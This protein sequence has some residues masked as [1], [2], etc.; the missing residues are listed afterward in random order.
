MTILQ[1]KKYFLLFLIFSFLLNFLPSSAENIKEP[2]L[3]S[4]VLNPLDLDFNGSIN[5]IVV[6]EM[7]GIVYVGGDFKSI[8]GFER[9]NLAAI[10]IDGTL[11]DWDPNV[12]GI[13]A[14]GI[15]ATGAKI[16]AL[17]IK[18]STIY[19]GGDFTKIGGIERNNLAAIGTNGTLKHWNPNTDGEVNALAIKG[20]TIYVGGGFWGVGGGG[21]TKIGET[22]RNNLAAIGTDGTL[23]SWNP[24]IVGSVYNIV[25][26]GSTIYIG[27]DF[28]I[29]GNFSEGNLAAIGTDGT[30]LDWNP[31]FGAS[32]WALATKGSTIYVGGNFTEVGG[33]ERNLLAAIGTE[34]TIKNWNP[35]INSDL[36]YGH[37]YDYPPPYINTIAISGSTI[38]VGGWFA[39]VGNEPRSNFASFSIPDGSQ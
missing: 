10:G 1:S 5:A 28:Y 35:N 3:K 22:G 29:V 12:T 9:N 4:P 13:T 30:F 8:G 15:N 19:V 26:K 17:A 16:N 32:V 31:G 14:T 11:L 38:Y 25:I 20:S 23:Q 24:G 27:G 33:I 6:D 36:Y 2:N 37:G 34:G 39:S 7:T 18:G 21:F